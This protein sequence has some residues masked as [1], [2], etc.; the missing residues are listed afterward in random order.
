MQINLGIESPLDGVGLT[1]FLNQVNAISIGYFMF[2]EGFWI[3]VL[4]AFYLFLNSKQNKP[5]FTF[6]WISFLLVSL[7]SFLVID[8]GRS[9]IYSYPIIFFSLSFLKKTIHI[10]KLKISA[11][12]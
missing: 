7:S 12:K 4:Y 8:H 6:T 1:T 2:L 10:E 5:L 3:I 11:D 9:I